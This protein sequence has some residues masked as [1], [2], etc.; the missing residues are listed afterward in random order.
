LL[1]R[2]SDKMNMSRPE[3]IHTGDQNAS[4]GLGKIS[5]RIETRSLGG[6]GVEDQSVPR[7]LGTP[8][9][10]D[11]KLSNAD[12]DVHKKST[13]APLVAEPQ[14]FNNLDDVDLPSYVRDHN[15][16]LT[17]PEKVSQASQV[18]STERQLS[19]RESAVRLY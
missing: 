13:D 12:T 10:S 17:L 15:S 9:K 8:D 14:T 5:V 16:T 2:L 1:K 18:P 11:K 3:S 19:R 4:A 6:G 7:K